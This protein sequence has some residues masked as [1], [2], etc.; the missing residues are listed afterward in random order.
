MTI[1]QIEEKYP[2]QLTRYRTDFSFSPEK[3]ESLHS[4]Q[5]RIDN[6]IKLIEGEYS[7][8]DDR[9]LIIS[10]SY[11]IRMLILRLI[12]FPIR[13]LWDFNLDN[14]GITIIRYQAGRGRLVCLNDTCHLSKT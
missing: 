12:G 9:I 10:H 3:G 6:F 13:H 5:Q 7:D 14:T 8:K 4:L 11:P 2:G 1:K